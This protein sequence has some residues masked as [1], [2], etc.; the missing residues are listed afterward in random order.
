MT[1]ID[2]AAYEAWYHTPRGGWIGER[3]AGLLLALMRPV[4]GKTLLDVG[5]GTGYFSRRFADAALKVTGIDPH[6]SMIDYAQTQGGIVDYVEGRA[7][8]LPFE[9][10]SFDYSAAVTSLCFVAEPASALA[11]MWRVSR[12]GVVLGLLNRHSLLYRQKRGKG[13]Y[14][15]A[16]W[17]SWQVVSQWIAQLVPSAVGYR[18]KTAIAFPR[19]GLISRLVEP[20]FTGSS[21]WGGFLAVYIAKRG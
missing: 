18:Y 3:E 9:D 14:A 12:F 1:A 11:E 19:G 21:P 4:V 8:C 13:A 7:E 16:R 17:D 10:G 15:G 20:L 2:P 5:C 6:E